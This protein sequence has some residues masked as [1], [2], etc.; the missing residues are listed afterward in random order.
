[1]QT[2]NL[3]GQYEWVC[4][5]PIDEKRYKIGGQYTNS[6]FPIVGEEGNWYKVPVSLDTNNNSIGYILKSEKNAYITKYNYKASNQA[7]VITASNQQIKQNQ[8]INL[9]DYVKAVDEEDN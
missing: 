1:M 8:V 2:V 4:S 5:S 7:P 3:E 9:K 6:Y